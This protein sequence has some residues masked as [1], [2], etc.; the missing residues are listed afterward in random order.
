MFSDQLSEADISLRMEKLSYP[1]KTVPIF[2]ASNLKSEPTNCMADIFDDKG[3]D[4]AEV[5]FEA[6]F[7]N[8]LKDVSQLPEQLY[9]G[10]HF[11]Y[12][13][14]TLKSVF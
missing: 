4:K 14:L 6:S 1:V 13:I 10:F 12:H 8:D 7:M 5:V 9:E 11:K 3:I 2:H